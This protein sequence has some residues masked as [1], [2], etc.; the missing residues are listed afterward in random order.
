MIRYLK[1]QGDPLQNCSEII[2]IK[3]HSI[4]LFYTNVTYIEFTRYRFPCFQEDKRV[5]WE[6]GISK[7]FSWLK[8]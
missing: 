7:Y 4:E 3:I 5:G 8:N 1:L 6:L 2:T